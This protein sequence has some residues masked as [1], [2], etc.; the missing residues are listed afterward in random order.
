MVRNEIKSLI[1]QAIKQL[2]KQKKLA[3]FDIPE[4]LVEHPENRAYGDYST[5]IALQIAKTIKKNPKEIAE[6]IKSKI[7]NPNYSKSNPKSKIQILEK[8]EIAGPG[9][10][11]FFVS[12]EF[13]QKQ[14]ADVL[15]QGDKF[16]SSKTG[17]GKTVV[18]DYSSPNIAKA[19]G[20]GHLRSTIIGQSLYNIYKFLGW[21]T[22][23]DNHLG[24]WGTQ[25]GKLIYQIKE[26]KVFLK[27]LTIEKLEKLYI[28]FHREAEKNPEMEKQARAWFQKLEARDKEAKKIWQDCRA[29]SLKEFQKI[30][31]LLG[32]KIDYTIG[33]SFYKDMAKDIIAEAIEKKV[34]IQSQGAIIIK[35]KKDKFPP[36]IILKSDKATTYLARDLAAV[37]YRISRW[38]PNLFIYEVGADQYLFLR[39]LFLAVEFLG[40]EK[41]EKFI[42]VVHGLVRRKQGKFSTRKG[43]T[44]HLEDVLKEA[45]KRAR[46]IIEK[47]ETSKGFSKKEKEKI[48]KMVGIGAIKYND[49]SQHYSKDI[50]F[51]WEKV[52]NLKGNSGPYLQYTIT[53]CQSVIKKSKVQPRSL[54]KADFELFDFK[55]EEENILKTIYKFPEIVQESADKFSPN[56]LCNFAFD[57]AQKYNHFYN[58]CPIIQAE[59]IKEKEFRLALTAA[60][61]QVLKNCL[62]LLG[63]SAPEKM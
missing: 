27:D 5:N 60:T 41:K 30:Y 25:F 57:L 56:L 23:G 61:S 62:N 37:K 24:D 31:N 42:H 49:L 35:Y 22:I 2:Q 54:Q 63:I 40:W 12:K 1:E 17:K 38:H 46:E 47:S 28:E 52:L 45:V 7:Q 39:Q 19:F 11:N 21:K 26:K 10:I 44:I 6:A 33:E 9:F 36:V 15:R 3:K 16:G 32:I 48:A 50:I 55:K 29:I 8:I 13:L 18:I 59:S 14:I 34:A 43:E 20:I 4:I 51:N 58:I 53:R